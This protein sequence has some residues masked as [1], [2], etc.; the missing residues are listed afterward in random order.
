MEAWKNL[1]RGFFM[2]RD[3]RIENNGQRIDHTCENRRFR[4]DTTKGQPHGQHPTHGSVFSEPLAGSQ[5][6]DDNYFN[7]STP[8]AGSPMDDLGKSS[9]LFESNEHERGT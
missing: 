1:I 2:A 7:S 6:Q 4:T 8:R 9:R 3:H 5:A